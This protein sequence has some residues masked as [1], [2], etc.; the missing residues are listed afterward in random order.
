MDQTFVL[1]NISPQVGKGFNRDKWEQLE[2]LVRDIASDEGSV[3][4]VQVC[5]GP[6]WAPRREADGK[7]YVRYEVIGKGLVAVPTHFFKVMAIEDKTGSIS[8]AAFMLP[9]AVIPDK[10]P[11]SSFRVKLEVVEGLSGHEFFT[12]IPERHKKQGGG[13]LGNRRSKL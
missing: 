2:S 10:A 3:K 6:I 11:L 13:L 5:T 9:N 8:I 12:R 4:R 7:N 1:T